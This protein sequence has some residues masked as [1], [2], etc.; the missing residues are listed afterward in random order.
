M[1]T[2]GGRQSLRG[3]E[4]REQARRLELARQAWAVSS[5]GVAGAARRLAEL[6]AD[7]SQAQ[8]CAAPA[9]KLPA[10]A[11]LV[12]RAAPKVAEC[13]GPALKVYPGL[14]AAALGRDLSQALGLWALARALDAQGAGR[15]LR[16]D[17]DKAALSLGLSTHKL[18]RYKAEA[19]A[20]GLLLP[21]TRHKDG[22]AVLAYVNAQRA[23]ALLDVSHM[24][25]AAVVVPA[26][27][28][29]RAALWK[30]ALWAAYHAGR[31]LEPGPISRETLEALS[32]VPARTQRLY[33]RRAGVK[34]TRNFWREDL[35]PA[36]EHERRDIIAEHKLAGRSA[37]VVRGRLGE[38]LLVTL[39]NSYEVR[40]AKLANVR[41]ARR[42]N[43][44]LRGLVKNAAGQQR[45]ERV[46]LFHD[47]ASRALR[48]VKRYERRLDSPPRV[49][50][51]PLRDCQS[52]S[53]LWRAV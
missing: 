10:L 8:A 34:V 49:C 41:T 30:S 31:S 36:A 32:G 45:Q 15:V 2:L 52:G 9:P 12:E 18:K 43:R 28:L 3:A 5:F 25:A 4:T 33:E 53:R 13:S 40:S 51:S 21:V 50:F 42:L 27:K 38:C 46:R 39:P 37:F 6:Q 35:P 1:L 19:L 26:G 23:A 16:A 7:T 44:N 17:F 24:G 29:K 11:A 14:A 22:A 48:A 47:D 20:A